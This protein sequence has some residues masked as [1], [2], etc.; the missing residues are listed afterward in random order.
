MGGVGKKKGERDGEYVLS[1][2]AILVFRNLEESRRERELKLVL[3]VGV[4]CGEER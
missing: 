1:L 2:F 4:R 3:N